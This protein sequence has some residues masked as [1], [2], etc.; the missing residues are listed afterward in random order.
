MLKRSTAIIGLG[1]IGLTYDLDEFGKAIPN[2]TMTHCRSVSSSQFFT[3]SYLIDSSN[4]A[5]RLAVHHYGGIGFASIS[6]AADQN[7]PELVIVSVPT[8]SQL[9][10][11]LDIINVWS[12]K[13]YLI[14]KPFGS[15]AIESRQMRD[16]LERQGARVFVNYFRRYLPNFISLKSSSEFARRGSLRS[17]KIDAYGSVQN[18]FSHFFDLLIFFESAL[19]LGVSKKNILVS[20]L[21]TIIFTDPD[22][23]IS[24]EL[25][26]IGQDAC[27]CSMILNYDFLVVK[28]FSNGRL[29]EI[30]D[31]D[32]NLTAQFKIE[33]SV[34]N[35]YQKFVFNEIEDTFESIHSN[36]CVS[37]A[38]RVH[39]FIE[40]I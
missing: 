21:G 4:E 9:K 15:S 23:K 33:N 17:V 10:V 2:Q 8:T 26:G 27:D 14:E 1:K 32:G 40:S 36:S 37:D 29:L 6:E 25:S 31:V 38:L 3:L 18:I 5:N 16:A 24:F 35:A 7:S 30:Y 19:V 39:E 13:L 28:M 11:V 12:P 22:S 34:F 20:A